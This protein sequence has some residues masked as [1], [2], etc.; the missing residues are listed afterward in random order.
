[1]ASTDRRRDIV[2]RFFSGTGGSY[3]FMVNLATLGGDRRWKRQIVAAIPAD[4]GRVLDLACG[5]GIST[6][7]I[8]RARPECR[9]VGVELRD[10]YLDIARGKVAKLGFEGIEFVQSRAEDYVS[11]EPFDCIVSS[12]LAKYADLPR[13]VK[14]ARTQLA[15]GGLFLMHDFSF[16]SDPRMARLWR[17]QF[18]A[19]QI[20]GTPLFPAWR[21]IFFD[22]PNL[23]ERSRWREELEESLHDNGYSNIDRRELS[24]HGS[25]M[26][27]ARR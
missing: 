7:A 19:L 17:L 20:I 15:E 23:I 26:I 9:V 1:M 27:T 5:T 22:L 14:N 10:E 6:L 11:E 3:D 24:A 2:E 25:A 16:P 18:R 13:L 8:A 4:A 21:D 12:Y